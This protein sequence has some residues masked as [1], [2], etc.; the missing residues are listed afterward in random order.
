MSDNNPYKA[1]ETVAA[2][3]AA[4]GDLVLPENIRQPILKSAPWKRFLGIVL[5]ISSGL[6]V[7]L[8]LLFMVGVSF[9]TSAFG[10]AGLGTGMSI[11]MGLIYIGLGVLY[12]FPGLYLFRSGKALRSFQESTASDDLASSAQSM[13]KFWKFC[14][15]LAIIGLSFTAVA[16]VIAIIAAIIAAI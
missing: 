6:L 10:A 13:S 9:L 3:T 11:F 16:I 7:V 5:F 15:I 12:L 14:G 1:P 8:G 4:G 2:A